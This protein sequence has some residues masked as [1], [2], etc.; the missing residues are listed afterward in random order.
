VHFRHF[1]SFSRFAEDSTCPSLPLAEVT[2]FFFSFFSRLR[3]GG[4][5]SLNGVGRKAPPS[6]A[7]RRAFFDNPSGS[8][9]V[10]LSVRS[11]YTSLF[12][13]FFY[14]SHKN[15]SSCTFLNFVFLPTRPLFFTG[16]SGGRS[17]V[18]SYSRRR[19]GPVFPLP[20]RYGALM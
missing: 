3:S 8:A 4:R 1:L 14:S 19:P 6:P 10:S 11:G 2:L 5:L 7:I 13:R 15:L 12:F 18:L 17:F 16:A 9:G 20:A